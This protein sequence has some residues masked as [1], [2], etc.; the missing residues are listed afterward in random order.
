MVPDE[1]PI[2]C[3]WGFLRNA[4]GRIYCLAPGAA[5]SVI[6]PGTLRVPSEAGMR[7]GLATMEKTMSGLYSV[8]CPGCKAELIFH[9]PHREDW[10]CYRCGND[11]RE[12]ANRMRSVYLVYADPVPKE[13]TVIVVVA[14][15]EA[16]AAALAGAEYVTGVERVLLDRK[17]VVEV[18]ER[19]KRR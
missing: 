7:P 6:R 4:Y 11:L 14:E 9:A 10:V 2:I 17:G 1:R 8:Y 5:E 12:G 18:V 19:G 13:T 15:S 16:E 3:R